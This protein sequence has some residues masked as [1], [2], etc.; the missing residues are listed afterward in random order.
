MS[1]PLFVSLRPGAYPGSKDDSLKERLHRIREERGHLRNI[2]EA[3]LSAKIEARSQAVMSDGITTQEEGDES[4]ASGDD[5]ESVQP[6]DLATKLQHTRE[7]LIRDLTEAQTQAM[8]ALDYLSL[9]ISGD[10]PSLAG[11]GLS[12]YLKEN[13]PSGSLGAVSVS[14]EVLTTETTDRAMQQAV[15]ITA[16]SLLEAADFLSA[17]ATKLRPK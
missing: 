9:L 10:K 16:E 4:S 2:N 3:A 6:E 7:T 17:K 13:I 8:A 12:P 5:S 1:S 15:V 11:Q 14:R